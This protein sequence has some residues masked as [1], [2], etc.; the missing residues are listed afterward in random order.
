M[1]IEKALPRKVR[2]R[3]LPDR[4][5]IRPNQYTGFKRY[6][7]IPPVSAQDVKTA[8]NPNKVGLRSIAEFF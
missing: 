3:L 1:D 7:Y 4:E 6:W 2:K 8:L 5:V